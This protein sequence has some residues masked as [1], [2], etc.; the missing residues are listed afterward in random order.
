MK[1][2]NKYII[3]KFQVSK[4]NIG[5]Y[6][7]HPETKE[8][9]REI[10][11]ERLDKDKNT[12]LNDIDVS[13]ITDMSMLFRGLNPH[14]IDVSEWDVSNIT[15]MSYMFYNCQNVNCNFD[16]WDVSKVTDMSWMFYSCYKFE[17]K[18]LE[19]WD[20][21]KV[22]DMNNMFYQCYNFNGDLS[23]WDVAKVTDMHCMFLG[24]RKFNADL[25]NWNV[26][27]TDA[28]RI[29]G[30]FYVCPSLKNMPTWYTNK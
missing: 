5:T 1:A 8:E 20:V 29:D 14:N 18:G 2:L 27:I 9:L 13:G 21:S 4:D 12:D 22:E 15:D 19:H 3:E 7:Y 17:G 25:S 30:M 23:D 6:K 16:I 28:P 26:N 24:C 10:L 11:K